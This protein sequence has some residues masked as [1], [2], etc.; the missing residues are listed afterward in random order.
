M[1]TLDIIMK[2]NNKSR[3]VE[4]TPQHSS[5]FHMTL[6]CFPLS[7]LSTCSVMFTLEVSL[8]R[9]RILLAT[10][11]SGTGFRKAV[12]ACESNQSCSGFSLHSFL[13]WSASTGPGA[14]AL[15]L[16]DISIFGNLLRESVKAH[17]VSG[18]ILTTSPIRLFT[19]PP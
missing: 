13:N 17:L 18:H 15:T 8:A 12:V 4:I 19:S 16:L 3:A 10:L 6:P 7:T 1:R 2:S 9:N 14:T 11:A 5:F